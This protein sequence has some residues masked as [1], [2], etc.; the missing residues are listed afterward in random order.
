MLWIHD[1]C[2]RQPE[3]IDAARRYDAGRSAEPFVPMD[4]FAYMGKRQRPPDHMLIWLGIGGDD[5][6]D[7]FFPSTSALSAPA[8]PAPERL[9]YY[10]ES[11]RSASWSSTR[12]PEVR[13]MAMS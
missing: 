3:L 13:T 5:L 2:A 7:F 12:L 9:G 11:S 6:P 4:D 1:E 10:V 8:S